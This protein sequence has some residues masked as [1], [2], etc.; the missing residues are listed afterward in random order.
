MTRVE[1]EVVLREKIPNG[2]LQSAEGADRTDFKSE[3][4]EFS[5]F[6]LRG[7]GRE[8]GIEGRFIGE[9]ENFGVDG[10]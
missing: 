4:D 1:I 6:L 2:F 9:R 10:L 7:V 5:I 8:D 3:D